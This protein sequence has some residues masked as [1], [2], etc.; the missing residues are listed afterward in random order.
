MLRRRCAS[1]Q[2]QSES[3]EGEGRDVTM[4]VSGLG[5]R[6]RAFE[7]VR[8]VAILGS[9]GKTARPRPRAAPARR[10]PPRDA[11]RERSAPSDAPAARHRQPPRL[12]CFTPSQPNTMKSART[13]SCAIKNGGSCCV[14]ASAWNKSI[15][16]NVC[17]TPTKQLNQHAAVAVTT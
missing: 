12:T 15:F 3:A 9:A 10:A 14:G 6:E 11:R 5:E 2:E 1:S 7:R 17:A 4:Q 8:M 16:M 13:A